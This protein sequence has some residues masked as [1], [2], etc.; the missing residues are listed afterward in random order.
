[1]RAINAIEG[2]AEGWDSSDFSSS[3]AALGRWMRW[4]RKTAR[5]FS[6]ADGWFSGG[7]ER[8]EE[9]KVEDAG[10]LGYTVEIHDNE[11]ERWER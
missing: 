6:R 11:R 2:K 5:N 8:E 4:R 10:E 3:R 7:K 1:M 9:L